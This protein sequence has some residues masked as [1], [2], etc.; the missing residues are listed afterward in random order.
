[1]NEN[2][3]LVP[4]AIVLAGGLIAAAIYFGGGATGSTHSLTGN[5]PG[6]PSATGEI[7]NVTNKDHI[8]GSPNAKV[9]IVEYSDTE[10]PFCKIF[11]NTMI[12]VMDS[13]KGKDVAWVYRHFPIA[14]LHSKA[15]KEAEATECAAEL[16]GNDGFWNFTN[17]VF[18]TTN[19]NDSLDPAELPKIAA[20]VGL[21]VTAFNA[22]LS[23]GKYTDAIKKDVEAAIKAGA[24]GTPYSV[25]ISGKKKLEISGA[26]PADAVKAAI[27]SLL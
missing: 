4:L 6:S 20:S 3:Q 11:H 9:I 1:M 5:S 16:G 19:S 8:V 21:D 27:D 23:S 2:K 12:S 22:C 13:Y 24:R 14:E 26:Q 17:K 25:V 10:C 7:E 18:A 15:A